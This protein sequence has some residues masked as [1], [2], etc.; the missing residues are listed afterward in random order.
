MKYNN[1][2]L[3]VFVLCGF[4]LAFTYGMFISILREYLSEINAYLIQIPDNVNFAFNLRIAVRV[5]VLKP[6]F[7]QI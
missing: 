1:C 4:I 2:D 7:N 3:Y 5:K 6:G